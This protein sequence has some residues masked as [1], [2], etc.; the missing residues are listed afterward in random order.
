MSTKA[1]R[2]SLAT[3]VSLS[4]CI[5]TLAVGLA[6]PVV[7]TAALP[8]GRAYELVSPAQKSGSQAGSAITLS[9]EGNRQLTSA[10]NYSIA[11]A[12]G[13][14]VLFWG[15]GP[16]GLDP[17]GYPLGYF[18][19][20]RQ[21]GGGWATRAATPRTLEPYANVRVQTEWLDPSADFSKIAYVGPEH[22]F[23][24]ASGGSCS[25]NIFVGGPDPFAPPTWIAQPQIADPLVNCARKVEGDAGTAIVGAAPDLGTVYFDYPGTLL[26][27][28]AARAP[29][30]FD[31][32]ANQTAGP[33]GF[34]EYDHGVLREAGVLPDGS[35]PPFGAVAPV[36][37]AAQTEGGTIAAPAV[38]GNAVSEDGSRAFFLSPDP[39]S[40]NSPV[41]RLGDCSEHDVC[42]NAPPELYV[43]LTAPDGTQSTKLVSEDT[44]LPPVNGRPAPAPDGALGHGTPLFAETAFM[45]A[46]PDGSHAFF[47]STDQ[48]TS[49]APADSTVK[50]YDFDVDNGSLTYLPGVAGSILALTPDGSRFAFETTSQQL[51]IWSTGPE[52]GTVKTIAPLKGPQGCGEVGA[53]IE[54]LPVARMLTD[55]SVFVFSTVAPLVG[56]NNGDGLYEQIYRYDISSSELNCV[57]CPPLGV[58]PSGNAWISMADQG[59]ATIGVGAAETDDGIVDERGI[60]ADGSRIFFDTPDPLVPQDVNDTNDVYE[61]E[62]GQVYL[63]SS[64]KSPNESIFLDNSESGGDVFFA[65]SDG[66]SPADT[67]GGYDVYDARIPR[68]GDS[69]APPPA[70]CQGE[71]CQTPPPAAPALGVPSSAAYFGLGNLTQPSESKRKLKNAAKPK[72]KKKRTKH[73]PTRRAARKVASSRGGGR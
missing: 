23:V 26:A 8:D 48:L 34:Y 29:H 47:E 41:E 16:M 53:Q 1:G 22:Q 28:D 64:G 73:R 32:G 7:S 12:E 63:I 56:F 42:T 35:V 3:C 40:S 50:T 21:Q 30:V 39:R 55:G 45:Y 5:A 57:S 54:C 13:D 69:P 58:V 33:S 37:G 51:A 71:I 59:E 11:S 60:S 20:Q 27:E 25:A 66:L 49:Q 70:T 43:R 6:A 18:V 44:L 36:I 19:A 61:W 17:D 4:L 9:L 72:A 14:A 38:N 65:T 10:V 62:Q 46:S 31:I 67:D 24:E 15:N 52:G 68:P 2:L